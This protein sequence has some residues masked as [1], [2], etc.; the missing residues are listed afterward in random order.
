MVT[1]SLWLFAG[2]LAFALVGVVNLAVILWS[3][4]D[5][6]GIG[7]R[8]LGAVGIFLSGALALMV[9]QVLRDSH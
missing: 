3:V 2:L 4:W 9:F 1:I 6:L 7:P 8:V 5:D